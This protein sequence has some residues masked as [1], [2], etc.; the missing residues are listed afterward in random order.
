MKLN[1]PISWHGGKS[2]FTSNILA[3]FP[4][5]RTYVEV[6][7]GSAAVLLAKEPSRVE[8]FND[9]DGDIVNLFR[10]LR[11]PNLS[12][13]LQKACAATLYARSEFILAQEP[14]DDPVERA[15]RF[16]VRQR[17]SRSGLGARWSWVVDDSRG[18]MAS[19]VRRWQATEERLSALHQRLRTVQIEQADWREILHRYDGEGTLFYLDPPYVPESRIGGHYLHEM[20]RCDHDDLIRQILRVK[21]KVVL[22]GYQHPSYKP[23]E[24]CGWV[25]RSYEVPAYSSDTR[26]RRV[27]QLWLSPTVLG[28]EPSGVD[29]MR[30]GAYRTHH[31][32]VKS[33]ETQLTTAIIRLQLQ[34]ER[35][36]ISAVAS[37]VGMSREHVSR[38]YRHLFYA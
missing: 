2:R 34:D 16:L 38:R 35:V 13:Q 4:E 18:G 21:G 7:G 33:A 19:V 28:R 30:S 6:F 31:H 12:P 20:T 26:S 10:V 14:T 29:R 5:H 1:P 3:V 24:S 15:R 37:M 22:S 27:E 25:R 23:L 32:R 11:D 17:M 8:V 36:T 9:V